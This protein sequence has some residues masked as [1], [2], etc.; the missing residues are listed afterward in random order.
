MGSEDLSAAVRRQ[1]EVLVRPGQRGA[2]TVVDREPSEGVLR[3]AG[4]VSQRRYD[5]ATG[6]SLQGA[7]YGRS[8]YGASRYRRVVR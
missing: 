8:G 5:W 2:A 4:G 6:T 3:G 1:T 7:L